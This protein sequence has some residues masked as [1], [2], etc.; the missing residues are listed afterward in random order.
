MSFSS[1]YLTGRMDSSKT[2][3]KR[4]GKNHSESVEV[5][6]SRLKVPMT[7]LAVS[8]NKQTLIRETIERITGKVTSHYRN[9]FHSYIQLTIT[10]FVFLL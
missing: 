7:R 3:K 10:W 9:P 2:G 4:Q 8:E 6:P 1:L 5:Q